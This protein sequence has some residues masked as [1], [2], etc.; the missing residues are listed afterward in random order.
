MTRELQTSGLL[1]LAVLLPVAEGVPVG[2][3]VALPVGEGEALLLGASE[4]VTEGE[5]PRD[6]EA[7]GE[8]EMEALAQAIHVLDSNGR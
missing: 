5:D 1:G 2:D 4:L 7:V 6:S 8:P 3:C